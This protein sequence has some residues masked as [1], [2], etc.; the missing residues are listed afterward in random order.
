MGYN[1]EL[2]YGSH[3][4][5]DLV[6]SDILYTAIFSGKK[7]KFYAP[8]KLKMFT[9]IANTFTSDETMLNVVSVFNTKDSGLKLY[10]DLKNEHLLLAY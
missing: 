8:E 6:E 5:Q 3:I 10:H 4:F 7:T 9:N 1:P 2:S